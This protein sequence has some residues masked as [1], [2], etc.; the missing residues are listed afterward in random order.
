MTLPLPSSPHWAP[1]KMVFAITWSGRG[2]EKP[3]SVNSGHTHSLYNQKV[4]RR[5][6]AVNPG[7]EAAAADRGCVRRTVLC[8][9]TW[10]RVHQQVAKG[11]AGFASKSPV[12]GVR[13]HH[14]A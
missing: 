4:E 10:V 9:S 7:A 3:R 1:I 2:N 13:W 11:S 8:F 6:M 12:V 5:P 14:S